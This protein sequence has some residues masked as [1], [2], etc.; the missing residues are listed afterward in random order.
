MLH[1]LRQDKN[2]LPLNEKLEAILTEKNHNAT[3][4][5]G[6]FYKM[7]GEKS[8]QANKK[9]NQSDTTWR[10]P[11]RVNLVWQY[12]TQTEFAFSLLLLLS[13]WYNDE[14]C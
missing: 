1:Q 2:C 6:L 8:F 12:K 11:D 9:Q 14:I 10:K 5:C 7:Q 4:S 13:Y 3:S